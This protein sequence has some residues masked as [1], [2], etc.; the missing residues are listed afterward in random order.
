MVSWIEGILLSGAL[1]GG[2]LLAGC[3]PAQGE[4]GRAR[5]EAITIARGPCFGFC[6]VYKVS[7]SPGGSVEYEGVRHTAVLG[8]R[9][10][11]VGRDAYRTVNR[12]LRDLRP[13][14]GASREY[15]CSQTPTDTSIMTIEWLSVGGQRTVLQYRMGC[16]SPEGVRIERLIDQQLDTLG[17]SDWAKRRPA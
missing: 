5:G 1:V 13:P 2:C 8:T 4:S 10:R 7:A 15:R 11:T 9:S 16:A 14:T 6:P 17:V 3:L 12:A